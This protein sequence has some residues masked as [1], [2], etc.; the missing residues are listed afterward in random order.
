MK[1][2]EAEILLQL[3]TSYCEHPLVEQLK[4]LLN[5]AA[6]F[7]V[8]VVCGDGNAVPA[9]RFLL[10]LLSPFLRDEIL[11]ENDSTGGGSGTGRCGEDEGRRVRPRVAVAS[12]AISGGSHGH[13]QSH[14]ASSDS[15]RE[16]L[17]IPQLTTQALGRLLQCGCAVCTRVSGFEELVELGAAAAFARMDAVLQS[18]V[19]VTMDRLQP[20][21]CCSLLLLADR[22]QLEAV[23]CAGMAAALAHFESLAGAHQLE[24]LPPQLFARLLQDDRLQVRREEQV[25]EAAAEYLHSRLGLLH[26]PQ[27]PPTAREHKWHEHRD[28][29]CQGSTE[30]AS[31]SL[32][33]HVCQLVLKEVRFGRM[34]AR[35]LR[36]QAQS[37][38]EDGPATLLVRNMIREALEL[39]L[40]TEDRRSSLTPCFI[41]PRSFEPR[42]WESGGAGFGISWAPYSSNGLQPRRM[43][44]HSEDVTSLAECGGDLVATGSLDG[45]IKLWSLSN[46][47]CQRTLLAQGPSVLSLVM[48]RGGE[49]LISGS[50]DGNL[51]LWEAVTNR[52]AGDSDCRCVAVLAAHARGVRALAVS[53]DRLY[54]GSYDGAIKIWDLSNCTCERTIAGHTGGVTCIIAWGQAILSGGFDNRIKRWDGLTGVC[55]RILMGHTGTVYTLLVH[56]QKLL[57]GSGDGTVRVWN[58]RQWVCERVLDC[59]RHWVHGLALV[60]GSEGRSHLVTC[61]AS[62]G[63]EGKELRVWDMTTWSCLHV[64]TVPGNACALTAVG[65]G[66]SVCAAVGPV[67][68]QWV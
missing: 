20:S 39:Q 67:V 10:A 43:A 47:Q 38:F 4:T 16:R 49:R 31:D 55:E 50:Y 62:Y 15:D 3:P 61:E 33:E 53:M 6:F 66:A 51:R 64:G 2:Q 68:L 27:D 28:H 63:R 35:Y 56:A 30:E 14:R 36:E 5:N 26:P 46:L 21:N 29:H 11:R 44:G 17:V 37:L 32:G 22:A 54:S 45:S 9:S 57:S 1:L 60:R 59:H 34:D 41:G 25:L 13:D 58:M 8:D 65:G 52:P 42:V 18:V 19:E 24:L 7:D 48:W 12:D 40:L 23:Q